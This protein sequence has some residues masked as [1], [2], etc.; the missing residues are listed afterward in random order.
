MSTKRVCILGTAESWSK[1][2]F[3]D[4]SIEIWALNDCYCLNIKRA[5]RWFELHPLDR[6]VFRPKTAKV[7]RGQIPHGWFVRPEGHIEWLKNFAKT[8]PVYLQAEPDA[9]WPVNAKRFPIEQAEAEFGQYWA[10]GPSYMVALAMLEGY[11]EI[12]VYGIHLATEEEYRQQ[13]SNF[14]FILGVARGRG[15]K[16]VM[17]ESSPVLRHP[18][19]YAY[20]DKPALPENPM[21]A[22][23]DATQKELKQLTQALV[24]WPVRKDK[25]RALERMK[26][27][28]VIALDI[29]QQAAKRS[30]G[31][32]LA[33]TV[34]A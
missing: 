32:T 13:R 34:A 11:T 25:T 1:A 33:I 30:M 27:L 12:Q 9:S 7:I 4:P 22:E 3:D 8:N 28:Q 16:V 18:W 21:K 5:D 24:N 19:R 31:G 14:E 26:R 15:I 6:M 20:D 23:W 17:A 10:S 2:P 29:Q